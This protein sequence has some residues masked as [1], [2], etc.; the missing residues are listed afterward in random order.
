MVF[1]VMRLLSSKGVAMYHLFA[2]K[3]FSLEGEDRVFNRLAGKTTMFRPNLLLQNGV[4]VYKA[5]Q[6]PGEFVVTFPRAYHGGFSNGFNCGEAVN[7]ALKD[8]FPFG[9]Y[10]GGRY[11]RLH[12]QLFIPYEELLVKEVMSLNHSAAESASQTSANA[13]FRQ[14]IKSLNSTLMSL[15]NLKV[16]FVYTPNSETSI[17][18]LCYHDCY[19]ASVR[20]QC[21][22]RCLFH[23]MFQHILALVES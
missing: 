19:L 13:C 6:M 17:C 1:Q 18:S 8:W 22:T 14:H 5:L 11:A 16:P 20:C 15:K 7:F 10:A 2:G 9:K 4:P 23:G 12:K 21:R 3:N